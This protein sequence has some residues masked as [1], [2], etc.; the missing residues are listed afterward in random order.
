VVF[1][2]ARNA[3]IDRL[4]KDVRARQHLQYELIEQDQ[5]EPDRPDGLSTRREA[6]VRTALDKLL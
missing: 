4:R 3:C 1:T 2:I 6:R 5:E